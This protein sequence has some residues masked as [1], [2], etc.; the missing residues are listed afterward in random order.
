MASQS[1]LLLPSDRSLTKLL[2]HLTS[3]YVKHRTKISRGIYLTLFVALVNRIRNAI[4]EQKA[5]A[6]RHRQAQ[7]ASV[8]PG[9]G[10]KRKKKVELNREFV[11]NLFKL[12]RIV[13][14]GVRSK[15]FR[16]LV[17]HTLFLVVRTLISLYVA[18][19]DGKLVS[20][21]VR[22]RG[23]DFLLGIVWWMV[24]AVPATFTNSMLSYHQCK[25]ALQYRTRLTRYIHSRYLSRMTFYTLG[26]LDDRI[27]NADQ[28]I[29]VDVSKFSNSLAE[30]YS[31]LAKPVLD[32]M[33]YNYQLSRNVGG[34]GL[35][36]MALLVQVSANVMRVLTPPFGRYVADEARLEGEFRFSHSRLIDNS[37][38]VA[39][40]GGHDAEK[41]TLDKGYFTLIKHVN[42]ILRRRLYHGMMED[43][44]IKY[45]WG[46]LG[47]MLCS[48]PVFF[49]VPGAR[50]NSLG[51]RTESRAP[52]ASL[53][54]SAKIFFFSRRL[55]HQPPLAPVVFGC[56][57]ACHVFLQGGYRTG[58]IHLACLHPV[59]RHGRHP[60]G[61][62]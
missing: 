42:Y 33:I 6:S 27:K 50:A 22:G 48:V 31:N 30:L 52:N 36:A 14:P 26:N 20:A 53:G 19:L 56:L 34:E 51:D 13:I 15:E 7:D 25:L 59:G 37:E 5:A 41:T 8:P 17:S 46:A 10:G 35:F 55:R 29:T 16:L 39:L 54:Y 4:S 18:E 2:S 62:L 57:W 23:K 11:H 58:G 45:F 3:L 12:L 40:Y 32:M 38:E 9:A 61:P 47:L 21:L 44:V 43:F 28:L 24:V 1:K 60:E 49:K